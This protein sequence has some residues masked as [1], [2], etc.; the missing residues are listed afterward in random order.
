MRRPVGHNG[1]LGEATLR[2]PPLYD[3]T[4]GKIAREFLR[5]LDRDRDEGFAAAVARQFKEAPARICCRSIG[6][7][8]EQQLDAWDWT[9]QELADRLGVDR[10]AVAKWTVGGA[11]SLGHLVLLLLEFRCEFADLPLPAR[12]ELALE[13]YLAAL[14]YVRQR[15][16]PGGSTASLDREQFWCLFHLLSEPHWERAIRAKDREL[17][18]KETS[19]VLHRAAESLG[20]PPREI[21]GV[22][23]LRRLV[24]N[25]AATWVVCLEVLP[26]D[27]TVR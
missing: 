3:E 24:E 11:I 8:I 18:R 15:L 5:K 14:T 9:Q 6:R 2:V 21:S 20:H 17:V 26:G 22:E 4:Y 16:T 25:W 23:D 19:R 13:G 7:W 12:R 1:R 10:S 27:W